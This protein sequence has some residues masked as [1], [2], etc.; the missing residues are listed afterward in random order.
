[1]NGSSDLTFEMVIIN[2]NISAGSS[3]ITYNK[4]FSTPF[5]WA[6]AIYSPLMRLVMITPFS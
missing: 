6:K 2:A 4:K 5:F 3:G 1:M